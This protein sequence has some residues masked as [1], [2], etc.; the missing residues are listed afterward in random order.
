MNFIQKPVPNFAKTRNHNSPRVIVVHIGEGSAN[1]IYNTFRSEEKSSHYLVCR[2]REIWQMVSDWDTAW[3]NGI[4]VRPIAKI[5]VDNP[6]L[7]PN[8][9]S[10]TIENEGFRHSI[11]PD[12][13]YEDNADLVLY[14]ANKWNIPLD[15]QYIMGHSEIRAD[16]ECPLPI[17]VDKV[18]DIARKKRAGIYKSRTQIILELQRQLSLLLDITNKLRSP[19]VGGCVQ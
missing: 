11:I 10:L 8:E 9:I 16:K 3:T 19:K 2:N 6:G 13:Q 18:L 17:S 7:K 4:K 14:L 1:T 12:T 15:R 5:I